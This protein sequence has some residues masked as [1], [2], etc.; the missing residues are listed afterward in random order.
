[1]LTPD[2]ISFKVLADRAGYYKNS[3]EGVQ[4]MCKIVEELVNEEKDD[5]KRKT[6]LKMLAKKIYSI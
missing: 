2:A 6:A 1:M 5:L 3:K 4:T